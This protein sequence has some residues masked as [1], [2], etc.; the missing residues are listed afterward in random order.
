VVINDIQYQ[1]FKVIFIDK[2]NDF[3]NY[4]A[5]KYDNS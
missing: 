1:N 2:K 4:V 3:L 5:L